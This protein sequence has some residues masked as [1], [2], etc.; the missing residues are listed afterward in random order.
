MTGFEAV[1]LYI[2]WIV[3][4]VL[5]YAGPRIPLAAFPE[6]P[7]DSRGPQSVGEQKV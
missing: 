2:V 1:L 5:V 4:L 3:A 6:R 7:R